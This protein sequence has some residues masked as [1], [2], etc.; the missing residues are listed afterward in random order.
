M[1]YA[2]RIE[3]RKVREKDFP[4]SGQRLSCTSDALAFARSLRESDIEKFLCLH[5]DARNKLNCIQLINGTHNQTVVYPREIIRHS[6][7]SGSSG[8]IL[9]HN[10]PSGGISPSEA[11]IRLTKIIA[12]MAKN[13]DVL[14]HDHIILGE[15]ESFFS[16][17][18]SG[19]MPPG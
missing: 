19:I 11:D 12:E 6:L 8:M 13:L 4:Y 2:Y 18:E 1:R 7:L 5:L 17:R 9:V 10:H 16:F 15:G 14:V 3:T